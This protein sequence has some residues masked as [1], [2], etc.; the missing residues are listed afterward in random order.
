MATCSPSTSSQRPAPLK[1]VVTLYDPVGKTGKMLTSLG[2]TV[3][4]WKGSQPSG[5]L[6]VIG[7]EALSGGKALP[8]D[9]QATVAAGG[10]VLICS[11]DPEWLRER[12]GFRVAS[13]PRAGFFS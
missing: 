1:Q 4:H 11:Q 9:L 10:R 13:H 2:Y 6:I 5:D 8:F 12:L 7:R 3:E